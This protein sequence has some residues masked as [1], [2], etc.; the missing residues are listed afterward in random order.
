MLELRKPAE[1]LEPSAVEAQEARKN[2]LKQKADK[3]R[4]MEGDGSTWLVEE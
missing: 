1:H 4:A 3:K 2:A